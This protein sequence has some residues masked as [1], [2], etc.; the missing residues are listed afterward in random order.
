MVIEPNCFAARRGAARLVLRCI[1]VS[2]FI[3][4]SMVSEHV[5][6]GNYSR[7][8]AVNSLNLPVNLTQTSGYAI[9]LNGDGHVDNAFG[10]ILS[11]L[12]STGLDISGATAAATTAGQ[13]VHL[14]EVRSS[15]EAFT[16]D[17]GAEAIWYIGKATPSP[18][19][20]DGTG[21]FAY[22]G[23]YAPSTFFAP[24][25]GGG[26]VSANPAT[27]TTPVDIT[28][29]IQIG[30]YV[31]ALP[32]QGARLKFLAL[33][34]GLAQGQIN[35]SIRDTDV[36]V[37]IFPTLA[38]A[39]NDIVQADPQSAIAQTLLSL[40]DKNPTDGFISVEEVATSPFMNTLFA[41][42][43]QIRDADGN[44]APNPANTKPDALSFGFGFSAV[45][46]NV[47]LP[48]IFANGFDK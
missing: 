15:D 6:A 47:V 31:V 13:I 38:D 3:C 19:L 22:D 32:L 24:L 30:N 21:T 17:A 41:P 44:Y 43:V 10:G 18:P 35:G 8:Y 42:D 14:V 34:S 37:K 26:F 27:T 33:G 1:L 48:P 2:G 5:H 46:S 23:D 20:F 29:D 16:N 7:A 28:V 45:E 9:D 11:A 25:S 39:F 40:F 36:Y 12:S 4:A